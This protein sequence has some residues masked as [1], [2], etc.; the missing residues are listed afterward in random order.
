[1]CRQ[2]GQGIVDFHDVVER[3]ADFRQRSQA[4][5]NGP[6]YGEF[7][8][9]GDPQALVY[10]LHNKTNQPLNVYIVLDV[11]FTNGTPQG[12]NVKIGPFSLVPKMLSQR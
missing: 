12:T 7:I 10:M 4:D 2:I 11:Q 5:P 3:R 9:R 8:P 1:M 6:E